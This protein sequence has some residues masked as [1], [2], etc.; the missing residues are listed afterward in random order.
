MLKRIYFL[1]KLNPEH[2]F[3]TL[4]TGSNTLEDERVICEECI[5]KIHPVKRSKLSIRLEVSLNESIDSTLIIFEKSE[6]GG[7]LYESALV[8]LNLLSG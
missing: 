5:Q 4:D 1:M 6:R 7:W 8:I 2:Q 3:W